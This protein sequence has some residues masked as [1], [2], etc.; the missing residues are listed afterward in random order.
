M[1][2]RKRKHNKRK[3]KSYKQNG[4][5]FLEKYSISLTDKITNNPTFQNITN[6]FSQSN[7]PE[8]SMQ[9]RVIGTLNGVKAKVNEYKDMMFNTTTQK[10]QSKLCNSGGS[11][12]RHKNKRYK[13]I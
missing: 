2:S 5:N 12:R 4:G 6:F 7:V 13:Q 8:I 9:E 1:R 3:N 10:I 11:K